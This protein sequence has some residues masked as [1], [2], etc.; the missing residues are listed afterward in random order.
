[1]ADEQ[2]LSFRCGDGNLYSA[3]IQFTA[4]H[5]QPNHGGGGCQE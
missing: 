2:F 3:K 1:M 4:D 5:L